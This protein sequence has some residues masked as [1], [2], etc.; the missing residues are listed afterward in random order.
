MSSFRG[1][2]PLLEDLINAKRGLDARALDDADRG[3][4]R[5][6]AD[7][8][9]RLDLDATALRLVADHAEDLPDVRDAVIGEIH[10]DLDKAAAGELEAQCLDVRQTTRGGANRFR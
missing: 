1:P 4:Q 5:N 3:V 2:A 6:G 8:L 7:D 10:R 9:R